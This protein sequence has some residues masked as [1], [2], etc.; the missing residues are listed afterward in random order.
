MAS[1]AKNDLQAI[2]SRVQLVGRSSGRFRT[3]P[4]FDKSRH[5]AP[6]AVN[7]ATNG[8]LARLCAAPLAEEAEGFFQRARVGLGYKRRELALDVTSPASVL[9]ARDFTFE[10]SYA[11]DERAPDEFVVTRTLHQVTD[12]S[13]VGR[14]AFD[15][16]FAG[17]FSEVAFLLKKGVQVEAVV[18]AVEDLPAEAGMSVE[19]PS[20]CRSCTLMVDGVDASVVCDGASLAMHFPRPGSPREL[21]EAFASVREAFVLT[22][23]RALSGLL[24]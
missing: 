10:I 6:D 16:L 23:H 9:T 21:L 15:E 11:L 17:Q 7:A 18:D 22:K 1:A 24:G 14:P 8:F 19:Y 2:V 12:A 3:L 4:G 5:V 13:V 20:D